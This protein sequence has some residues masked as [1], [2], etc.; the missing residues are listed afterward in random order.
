MTFGF[1]KFLEI[2]IYSPQ[3]FSYAEKTRMICELYFPMHDFFVF[4]I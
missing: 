4:R 1:L 3:L 2:K